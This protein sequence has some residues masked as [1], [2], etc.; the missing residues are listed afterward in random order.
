M[1]ALVSVSG[2]GTLVVTPDAGLGLEAA[3]VTISGSSDA[4]VLAEISF[5]TSLITSRG[6]PWPAGLEDASTAAVSLAAASLAAGRDTTTSAVTAPLVL[7][8][9]QIGIPAT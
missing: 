4:P 3:C 9:Y 6:S 5:T 2:A 7:G 1:A 8:I